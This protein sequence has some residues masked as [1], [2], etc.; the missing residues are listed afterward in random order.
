MSMGMGMG[1][2]AYG[3]MGYPTMGGA[4]RAPAGGA[5]SWGGSREAFGEKGGSGK[6]YGKDKDKDRGDRM[7]GARN[8]WDPRNARNLDLEM[9]RS[10]SGRGNM[11][12]LHDDRRSPE[13][14]PNRGGSPDK[15]KNDLWESIKDAPAKKDLTAP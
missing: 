4:P 12:S 7:G 2:P 8:N 1:Y 15:W 6:G 3:Y 9:E 11:W 13:K 14:R 5:S 10:G